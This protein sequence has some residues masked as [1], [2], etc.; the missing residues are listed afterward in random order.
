MPRRCCG[1]RSCHRTRA[2]RQAGLCRRRA[3][4]RRS[5]AGGRHRAGGACGAARRGRRRGR[6][7]ARPEGCRRPLRRQRTGAP[8]AART[9][10]TVTGPAPA[11][12]NVPP[13]QGRQAGSAVG[14]L[15]A[16]EY[17]RLQELAE[18]IPRSEH[19]VGCAFHSC[20]SYGEGV[21]VT[22]VG[23]WVFDLRR[24]PVWL[25]AEARPLHSPP[26]CRP[27]MLMPCP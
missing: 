10:F 3:A 12:K 11:L 8:A 19:R 22:G 27:H 2:P 9:F 17:A 1:A 20:G 16:A 25:P 7:P 23:S 15:S 21:T 24:S 18:C 5:R 26:A 13:L 6:A 14:G 4:G